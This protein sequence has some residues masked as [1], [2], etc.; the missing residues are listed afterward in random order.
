V[1]TADRSADEPPLPPEP[2][3]LRA[4]F[5]HDCFSTPDDRLETTLPPDDPDADLAWGSTLAPGPLPE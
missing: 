5:L 1:A 4:R 2:T 3:D